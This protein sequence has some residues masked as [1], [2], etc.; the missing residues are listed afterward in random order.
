M[1]DPISIQFINVC[2]RTSFNKCN[3]LTGS[4]VNLGVNSFSVQPGD[5]LEAD[6]GQ[7]SMVM[8]SNVVSEFLN[9]KNWMSLGWRNESTGYE[10][11]V[12]IYVPV[13]VIG[14]GSRPYYQIATGYS[15]VEYHDVVDD[16]SKPWSLSPVVEV[17]YM[18]QPTSSHQGLAVVATVKDPA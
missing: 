10:F 12:K 9:G 16:P 14:I 17:Q 4:T 6:G 8:D 2:K 7:Q 13:Q 5:V 11:G 3:S 18:I 15:S 1:A